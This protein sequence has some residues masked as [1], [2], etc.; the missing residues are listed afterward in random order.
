MN[1]LFT[2]P[3]AEFGLRE[4]YV[5]IK[6]GVG[7][8]LIEPSRM[9]GPIDDFVVSLQE[10]AFKDGS[11][12]DLPEDDHLSERERQARRD[13][14]AQRIGKPTL[15]LM[16]T[17]TLDVDGRFYGLVY[18]AIGELHVIVTR[19][20][21]SQV[22]V[23]KWSAHEHVSDSSA[24]DVSVLALQIAMRE[25][26]ETHVDSML[27]RAQ[28]ALVDNA[29]ENADRGSHGAATSSIKSALGPIILFELPAIY[30]FWTTVASLVA[31]PKQFRQVWGRKCD[32]C[33]SYLRPRQKRL[34]AICE[35][36]ARE[37]RDKKESQNGA[38]EE[39]AE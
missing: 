37:M 6:V 26:F 1:P 32:M 19:G 20:S 33:G 18:P 34:C 7:V 2:V 17:T 27:G 5:L 10:R 13:R 3:R 15:E 28:R 39:K 4:E 21:L 29:V 36:E 38:G 35:H 11:L 9:E 22:Q 31:L 23:E 24:G 30:I 14:L 25:Q 12:V 8:Y 16:G